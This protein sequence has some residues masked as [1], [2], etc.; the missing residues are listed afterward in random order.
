VAVGA[1][2]FAAPRRMAPV[3]WS[4]TF[5]IAFKKSRP[6]CFVKVPIKILRVRARLVHESA[7]IKWTMLQQN[8]E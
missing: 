4:R 3:L 6:E 7:S 8:G 2:F 1:R 5:A